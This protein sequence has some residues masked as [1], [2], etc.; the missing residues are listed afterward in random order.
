LI[1]IDNAVKYGAPEGGIQV[2]L[3][4]AEGPTAEI[5]VRDS[6]PGIEPDE[7]PRLFERFYRGG[8]AK[9]A[10]GSGLGLSIARWIV[11]KHEGNLRLSSTPGVGT[12]VLIGLPVAA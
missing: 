2:S 1:V 4:A 8:N 3:A 6:G 10:S 11:E 5:R 12:E 7:I 9:H